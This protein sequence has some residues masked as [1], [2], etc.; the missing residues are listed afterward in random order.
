MMSVNEYLGQSFFDYLKSLDDLVVI[1][2]ESHHYRA[3]AS[4]NAIN[5]LEPILGI[6]LTAT[7]YITVNNKQLNFKKRS[8]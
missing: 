7:P 1:M 4:T 5:S 3:D 6:E 2:D 8:L